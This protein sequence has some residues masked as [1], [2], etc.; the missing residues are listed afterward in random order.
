[1]RPIRSTCSI[2]D[3]SNDDDDVSMP[4]TPVNT[5]A[6]SRKTRLSLSQNWRNKITS[7]KQM[8]NVKRR[9]LLGEVEMCSETDITEENVAKIANTLPNLGEDPNLNSLDCSKPSTTRQRIEEVKQS[10]D[11]WR[12]GCIQALTDL[13]EIRGSGDMESLLNSLQIPFDLVNYDREN[14]EFLDPD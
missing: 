5:K 14:Q 12:V 4:V 3:D 8:L 13:Q 1:M 6:V 10:I 11:V 2:G 7:K 9:K